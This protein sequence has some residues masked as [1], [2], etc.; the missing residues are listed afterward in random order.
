[1]KDKNMKFK[2]LTDGIKEQIRGLNKLIESKIPDIRK[3]IDSIIK[4]NIK[5]RKEIESMLDI[6]LD[7][8][9]QGYGKKEFKKLNKYYR[10]IHPRISKDYDKYYREISE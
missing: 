1:M 4:N 7:Y 8:A 6:L 5:D 10:K 2:E 3:N 9:Y